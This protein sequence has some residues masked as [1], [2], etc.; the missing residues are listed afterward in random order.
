V[1]CGGTTQEWINRLTLKVWK[2]AAKILG[3]VA[4]QR[5]V[6]ASENPST[7]VY[8]AGGGK[9]LGRELISFVWDRR[10]R[11]KRK[12]QSPLRKGKAQATKGV[13]LLGGLNEKREDGGGR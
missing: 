2:G 4:S 9:G 7:V 8:T 1:I 5:R 12:R 6:I 10:K 11:G 3:K 13:H